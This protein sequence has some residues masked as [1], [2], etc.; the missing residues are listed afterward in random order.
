MKN[1]KS[2]FMLILF[3]TIITYGQIPKKIEVIKKPKS[4]KKALIMS[5]VVPG[6]GQFYSKSKLSGIVY[7]A[8]EIVGIT[9]AIW[10]KKSGE[11]SIDEYK[12]YADNKW[13]VLEF[14]NE[15]YGDPKTHN[16]IISIDGIKYSVRDQWAALYDDFSNGY[17]SIKAEKDY[18]FYENIGKYKQFQTGWVDY[19][20]STGYETLYRSSPYQVKYSDMRF[21]ANQLLKGSTYVVSA[22]MFNHIVSAIDAMI[23]AKKYNDRNNLCFK[24]NAV[25]LIYEDK[26]AILNMQFYW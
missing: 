18:H 14:M 26:G 25:P 19:G 11:N 4:P 13:H 10:L 3:F 16:M 6:A 2:I 17:I 22:V 1:I 21:D 7:G 24:M 23:R 15:Y 9:S 5:G 12:N 8:L 20:D